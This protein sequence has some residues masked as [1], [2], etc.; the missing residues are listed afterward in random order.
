MMNI[1]CLGEIYMHMAFIAGA[2]LLASYLLGAVPFALI[3]GRLKGVDI[4]K[5][6]SGNLGATNAIRV[7]G[8]PVGLTVFVLDFLKGLVPVLAAGSLP[9]T[10]PAPQQLAFAFA[11]GVAA[12]LGHTFP[13][14]LRFKGGKGVAATAGVMFAIRWDAALVSFAMFFL[15]R[16]LTGYVSISS[17]ALAVAFPTALLVFHWNEAFDLYR[18]VLVGSG[19]LALLIIFRHRGNIARIV[20]GREPKVGKGS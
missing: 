3:A 19:L 6:G 8:K 13:V 5:R 2:A 18:W 7:L 20:Q 4:R 10:F 12:V 14:Y 17:M 9:T 11:C 1:C 15:V 16:K